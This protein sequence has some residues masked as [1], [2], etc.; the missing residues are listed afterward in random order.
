MGGVGHLVEKLVS[1]GG[2]VFRRERLHLVDDEHGQFAPPL[3][4]RQFLVFVEREVVVILVFARQKLEAHPGL[5]IPAVDVK[6]HAIL[7]KLHV[8]LDRVT[9][10]CKEPR[11][12]IAALGLAERVVHRKQELLGGKTGG[13]RPNAAAG[14]E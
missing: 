9:A 14:E 2:E 1:L 8:P 4:R 5:R 3:G 13:S 6:L 7:A 11:Q 12:Q 10:L